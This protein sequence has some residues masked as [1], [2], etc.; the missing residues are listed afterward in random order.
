MP[1]Y[2]PCSMIGVLGSGMA[3]S[4]VQLSHLCSQLSSRAENRDDLSRAKQVGPTALRAG[5]QAAIL[6][7]PTA[8]LANTICGLLQPSVDVAAHSKPASGRRGSV[9]ASLPRGTD[10]LQR[11]NLSLQY[12]VSII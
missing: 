3:T 10:V 11:P 12:K 6:R 8:L 2:K 5:L 7:D 4:H 1:A 9:G